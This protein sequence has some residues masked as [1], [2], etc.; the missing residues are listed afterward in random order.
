MLPTDASIQ[1]LVCESAREGKDNKISLLGIFPDRNLRL[2]ADARFPAAFPVTL[3]F[4]VLDGEGLF[5]G[6]VEIKTSVSQEPPI[7]ASLPNL[8]KAADQPATITLA[9]M[10]FIAAGFGIYEVILTLNGQKYTRTFE[11][12]RPLRP[13]DF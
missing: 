5:N 7:S 4:F 3:V 1:F 10:P 2:P 12:A 8:Q 6:T 11:V 9:F 13:L